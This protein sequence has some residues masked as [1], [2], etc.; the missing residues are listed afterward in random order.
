M[1]PQLHKIYLLLGSNQQQPAKQLEHAEKKVDKLIGKVI[2]KSKIY[3]TEAWGNVSQPDFLNRVLVVQTTLKATSVLQT[4]LQIE[5]SMGRIR[6]KRYAPRVID[7]DILFFDKEIIHQSNLKV[8]H[9]LLAERN[10]VL[11]P[12]NELSPQFIHPEKN[13]SV[14]ELMKKC[15]DTL[16][17]K[18]I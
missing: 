9:P 3:Q 2:R 7:I 15:K 17:V 16:N 12:L 6:T 13:E 5:Q 10:F 1:G 14:H 11:V 8:P 4:I 18:R